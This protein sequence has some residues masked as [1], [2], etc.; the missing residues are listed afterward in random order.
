VRENQA[1]GARCLDEGRFARNLPDAAGRISVKADTWVV[2]FVEEAL[3]GRRRRG[4]PLRLNVSVPHPDRCG[5]RLFPLEVHEDASE[6]VGVLLN[7]VV[8]ALDV[9]LIEPTQDVLLQRS[10]ALAGDDLDGFGLDPD[11]F[12]DDLTQGPVDVAPRCCRSRAGPTS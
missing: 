10:G 8:Q 1:A 2:S 3:A 6:V 5:Q 9:L 11:G 12:I 7:A 4:Q